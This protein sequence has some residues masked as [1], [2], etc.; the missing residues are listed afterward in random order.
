MT[1]DIIHVKLV[2][3]NCCQR[4]ECTVCGGYTER[5]RVVAQAKVTG[6]TI[7][8]CEACLMAKAHSNA[9]H[10][11]ATLERNA[12][13]AEAYARSV[14]SLKGR[15]KL[16]TYNE[17]LAE[18]DEA[19]IRFLMAHDGISR[20]EVEAQLRAEREAWAKEPAKPATLPD[21]LPF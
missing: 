10:I 1:D 20:D 21:D 9:A 13:R 12:A 14:R 18:E 16:P 4:W 17:W 3:T 19:E 8:V 5:V 6:G 2:H 7:R 11:D 15:L